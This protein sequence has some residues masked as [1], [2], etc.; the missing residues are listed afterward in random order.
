M[1]ETITLHELAV[2]GDI[3]L[4]Q[5]CSDLVKGSWDDI[6]SE[7]KVP[8]FL[9]AILRCPSCAQSLFDEAITYKSLADCALRPELRVKAGSDVVQ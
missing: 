3:S 5:L 6:F 2:A 4:A 9:P 7:Q 1:S 8:K